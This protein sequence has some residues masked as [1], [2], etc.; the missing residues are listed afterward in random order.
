MDNPTAQSTLNAGQYSQSMMSHHVQQV[1]PQHQQQLQHQLQP[2]ASQYSQPYYSHFHQ[3]QQHYQQAQYQRQIFDSDVQAI[4]QNTHALSI[5]QQQAPQP[6]HHQSF[7]SYAAHTT[8]PAWQQPPVRQAQPLHGAVYATQQQHQHQHQ[9]P[10]QQPQQRPLQQQQQ[11][12]PQVPT[13]QR[14]QDSQQHAYV[15]M[16]AQMYNHT[17]RHGAYQQ[18]Q[19]QGS[20]QQQQQPSHQ[21]V[22]TRWNYTQIHA[23]STTVNPS[24]LGVDHIGH[25]VYPQNIAAVSRVQQGVQCAL[26]TT[27]GNQTAQDSQM[28]AQYYA[29]QQQVQKYQQLE[30]QRLLNHQKQQLQQQQLQQQQ[31]QLQQQSQNRQ[32][33]PHQQRSVP[34][35]E[36]YETLGV[37]QPRIGADRGYGKEGVKVQRN[38]DPYADAESDEK[39]LSTDDEMEN[40]G[41]ERKG[42][43]GVEKGNAMAVVESR[44]KKTDLPTRDQIIPSLSDYFKAPTR[45]RFQTYVLPDCVFQVEKRYRIKQA[46]GH[47]AYGVVCSA[48]DM[49]TNEIVAVKR[50]SNVFAHRGLA[51]RTLREL[52]FLRLLVHP[53]LLSL[54]R[55][56]RPKFQSFNDVYVVTE[57]METDLAN[58][59][60]SE[61][62]LSNAHFKFFIYQLLLGLRV[63]HRSGCIH[64]DLKPRNLLINANCDL[65]ICDFG[66]ARYDDPEFNDDYQMSTYVATRWYRPPEVI[67]ADQGYGQPADIWAVG[68]ILAELIG[69][70]PIFPGRDSWDQLE[71]IFRVLGTPPKH[72]LMRMREHNVHPAVRK[73]RMKQI[74]ANGGVGDLYMTTSSP[75]LQPVDNCDR[76]NGIPKLLRNRDGKTYVNIDYLLEMDPIE[77]QKLS[78]LYPRADHLALDLLSKLLSFDPAAR[79]TV[80]EALEHPYL[81]EFYVEADRLDNTQRIDRS[82]FNFERIE[83][84]REDL[85]ALIVQEIFQ[86]NGEDHFVCT[87]EQNRMIR[88]AVNSLLLPVVFPMNK[89]PRQRSKSV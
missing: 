19:Q 73:Q 25:Q 69:R 52:K 9:Q 2:Q 68:C 3:P 8:M 43:G 17:V 20:H 45:T 11:Q 64:R 14:Q 61:Q 44:E 77:P 88:H 83:V 51:K 16:Q 4:A 53:N 13:T 47:G 7:A 42:D 87:E 28:P 31:Q 48:R 5:V 70:Q 80:D 71:R 65:K 30:Q 33:M 62:T 38:D 15:A 29:Q 57:H 79:P 21:D 1:Q 75:H 85:R 66:L 10:Q 18:A 81:N 35:T 67:I 89:N 27:L 39:D 34:G 24:Q 23:A 55:V 56:M 49:Q 60:K 36:V 6:Q 72:V 58:I 78:N 22:P 86:H 46:L 84:T 32:Q 40:E 50:M 12:Q 54:K 74:E 76:I 41:T 63:I 59:I 82:V 37:D 26:E